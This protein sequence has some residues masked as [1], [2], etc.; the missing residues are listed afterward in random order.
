MKI[1]VASGKGGTGKTI[2]ATN[3]AVTLTRHG[4]SVAYL[5]CDVEEPNGHLFLKPRIRTEGPVVWLLPQVDAERCAMCGVCAR[6]CHFNAIVCLGERVLVFGDLCH[7]CGGCA[8]MCPNKAISEVP[9]RT[10]TVRTG[11]RDELGFVEGLLNVGDPSAPPVIRVVKQAAPEADWTLLDAP[12]GT[13]CPVVE[14]LRGCDYVLLV[15]EPT[16]FGLHDLKLAVDLIRALELPCGVVINRVGAP[17]RELDEFLE[18][19]GI[20]VLARLP[21]DRAVAEAYARGELICDVVPGWRAE[22]DKLAQR[23]SSPACVMT[24]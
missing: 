23:L 21:D 16:P 24:S 9:H 6:F 15:T 12:P 11:E 17:F 7:A 3:L 13:G 18:T 1:A 20:E 8:L 2:V 5:D 22:M 4:Q 14:T 10:G 19:S